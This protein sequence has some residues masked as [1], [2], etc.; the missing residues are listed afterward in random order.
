MSTKNPVYFNDHSSGVMRTHSWRTVDNSAAY[1]KPHIKPDMT[2]LD[3]GCGPGSITVGLASLVPNGRVVGIEYVS[4]PLDQARAL[5][6]EKGVTNVEF[7]VGDV[8][9]LDFPDD[10]FDVV[11]VHQVLQHLADPVKAIQEMRRVTKPKG[12]FFAAREGAN[13]TLYP[14]SPRLDAFFKLMFKVVAARGGD[15]NSGSYIHTLA[16][17]AGFDRQQ[18]KCSAGSWCFSSPE[19]RAYFGGSMAERCTS[20]GFVKIAL[21]EGFAT[22]EEMA[23]YAQAWQ[24]F[25]NDEYAWCGVF[26]GEIICWK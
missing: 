15:P 21:D 12:G 19:E 8:Y 11:H 5:A 10:H 13:F 26:H 3:V 20:S 1:L 22:P 17:K 7:G 2:I 4:D 24:D 14:E 25:V 6:A 16:T 18:V 9:S 23:D